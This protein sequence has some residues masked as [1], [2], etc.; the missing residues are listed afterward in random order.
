MPLISIGNFFF[1][2]RNNIFPVMMLL[3][4]I[5]PPAQG[6]VFGINENL[7][8][9]IGILAMLAGEALRIGVVGLKYIIRG[10]L[11]KK[12]YAADLV[13]EGFFSVC[14]NPLYVG[15]ILI[16]VGALLVHAQPI[17]MV[18]GII[19]ILFIYIAIVAAEENF[20]RNKFGSG[21]DAYCADVNRW[22]P[23]LMRLPE[24]SAGMTFN[25]RRVIRKEYPQIAGVAAVMIILLAAEIYRATGVVPTAGWA[26]IVAVILA[27]LGVRIAKKTGVFKNKRP[28]NT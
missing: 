15:N 10:G 25:V 9:I 3:L 23:N 2:W 28:D 1:K 13:T 7:L 19:T 20:L 27:T 16:G 18:A 21:Y 17:L 26:G 14:R 4:V 12:V 5:V 6:P 11:D 8:D 24:A 22:L